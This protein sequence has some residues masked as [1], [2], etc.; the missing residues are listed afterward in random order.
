LLVASEDFRHEVILRL[1]SL[2][3]WNIGTDGFP[4][5]FCRISRVNSLSDVN[6]CLNA[7]S[8]HELAIMA[9]F[10][11]LCTK[12]SVYN[13]K[14][15]INTVG[16]ILN[17]SKKQM[18][19]LQGWKMSYYIHLMPLRDLVNSRDCI[20]AGGEVIDIPSHIIEN[21]PFQF[22]AKYFGQ[23]S[24][25]FWRAHL[26][27]DI[28]DIRFKSYKLGKSKDEL[29]FS[30]YVYRPSYREDSSNDEPS[31]SLSVLD[32]TLDSPIDIV[33]SC[34]SGENTGSNFI[35]GHILYRGTLY[36]RKDFV[37]FVKNPCID[38]CQL[39]QRMALIPDDVAES[40]FNHFKLFNKL[41][42]LDAYN[43]VVRDEF[44]SSF[45]TWEYC[46]FVE[47]I[48]L[49][50]SVTRKNVSHYFR[51]LDKYDFNGNFVFVNTMLRDSYDGRIFY[52]NQSLEL[53]EMEFVSFKPMT[54][55]E[56]L[57]DFHGKIVNPRPDRTD[58]VGVLHLLDVQSGVGEQI[59]SV[60]G[61]LNQ[62]EVNQTDDV[63]ETKG[64]E[65]VANLDPNLSLSGYGNIYV[66][67]EFSKQSI[68]SI[69]KQIATPGSSRQYEWEKDEGLKKLATN[70]F[71]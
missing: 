35:K 19:S 18:F 41:C 6:E 33:L 7:F 45:N 14:K 39:R 34:Q 47:F 17:S 3:N 59:S 71:G 66:K 23:Q 58:L 13:V 68:N 25:Q 2:Y 22:P 36:S 10:F 20:M 29:Y 56:H 21:K 4:L 62:E 38:L 16:H 46:M 65:Q 28:Q 37:D 49:F 51:L 52:V 70:F 8:N 55:I 32:Q 60:N 9:E 69:N 42:I 11:S 67:H 64:K 43:H 1:S 12:I 5:P 40:P 27:S 50:D 31:N 15:Y 26:L 48:T 24:R 61:N 44:F 53:V 57:E 54:G 30:F 63:V